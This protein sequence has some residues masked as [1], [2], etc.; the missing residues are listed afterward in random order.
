M[1]GPVF[2]DTNVLVYCS[3]LSDPAKRAR[4]EAWHALLWQSRSGRVSF[5]VLLEPYL[6]LTRKSKPGFDHEEARR[7][8][9][10][11]AAWRPIPVDLGI[12]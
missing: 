8:V 3:D 6:T 5:Q 9:R 2:V 11:L 12:I 10:D 7:T 1:I 4:A